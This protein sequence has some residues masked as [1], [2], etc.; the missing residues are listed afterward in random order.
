MLYCLY[1]LNVSITSY[2]SR[3]NPAWFIYLFFFSKFLYFTSFL[4]PTRILFDITVSEFVSLRWRCMAVDCHRECG[5]CVDTIHNLDNVICYYCK[6]YCKVNK[7]AHNNKYTEKKQSSFALLTRHR[8][9]C[10]NLTP[11]LCVSERARLCKLVAF[12]LH[13]YK[14]IYVG[15]FE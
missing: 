13:T 15:I 14:Y 11:C 12:V 10:T 6:G 8:Y 1:T 4:A 2:P 7:H 3:A 5:V 9:T